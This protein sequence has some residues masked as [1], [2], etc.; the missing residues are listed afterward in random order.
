MSIS[1]MGYTLPYILNGGF[2]SQE[3][4]PDAFWVSANHRPR[5]A[6]GLIDFNYGFIGQNL[7]F[8]RAGAEVKAFLEAPLLED[9]AT[10]PVPIGSNIF[11]QAWI[12]KKIVPA[13][14]NGEGAGWTFAADIAALYGLMKGRVIIQDRGFT[15]LGLFVSEDA[16]AITDWFGDGFGI[17]G[18]YHKGETASDDYFHIS[19]NLPQM[20]LPA[21]RMTGGVLA[22]TIWT[23]G[24]VQL[25]FGFPWPIG[26]TRQWERTIG[27]IITPGQASAGFYILKRQQA[28]EEG[29]ELVIGAGFALQWGLGASWGGG[30]FQAWGRIGVYGVLTGEAGFLTRNG[31]LELRWLKVTGAVGVLVEGRGRID[32]WII[33]IEVGV[34]ATAEMRIELEYRPSQPT[35]IDLHASLYVSAY[36]RACIGGGWFKVCRSVNVGLSIPVHHQLSL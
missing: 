18:L 19:L 28:A 21:Y 9:S 36:A 12:D 29:T 2:W 10:A 34:R 5:T 25:D 32:W 1:V 8:S 33:S 14:S 13:Q 11:E 4:G 27:M 24:G 22:V 3:D 35:R 31:D 26:A 15:G 7:D 20:N 17:V 30:A 16:R 23:N 6:P